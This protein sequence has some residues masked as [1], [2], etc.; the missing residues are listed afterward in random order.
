M[1]KYDD[2]GKFKLTYNKSNINLLMKDILDIM[3][4]AKNTEAYTTNEVRDIN[5]M[6]SVENGDQVRVGM[7]TA[8]LG[9]AISKNFET[10]NKSK[11]SGKK[12]ETENN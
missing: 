1:P 6:D 5:D 11:N 3:V 4:K 10:T 2:T 12:D 7:T 9:E 8:P